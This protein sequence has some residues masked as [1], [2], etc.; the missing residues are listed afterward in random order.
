[1]EYFPR[2]DGYIERFF[3]VMVYLYLF[4]AIINK[5]QAGV[6]D[7]A[8]APGVERGQIRHVRQAGVGDLAVAPGVERGQVRQIFRFAISRFTNQFDL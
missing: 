6:G 1:M 4:F 3:S 5:R 8:V 7:P 2:A